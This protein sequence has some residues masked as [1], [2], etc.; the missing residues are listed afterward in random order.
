MFS[1]VVQLERM[2]VLWE[3]L[4]TESESFSS[5]ITEKEKELDA[6]N[7]TTSLD[8]LDKNISMVEVLY[9]FS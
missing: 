5:W 1:S 7:T 3:S 8:P 2:C 6:I 9:S 4:S